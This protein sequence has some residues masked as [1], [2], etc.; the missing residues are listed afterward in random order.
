V[1]LDSPIPAGLEVLANTACLVFGAQQNCSSTSTP[2]DASPVLQVVKTYDGPPLAAGALLTFHLAVTNAGDQ[3]AADLTVTE[4]VPDH[5]TFVAG[6]STSGW[7][8]SG[9]NAGASCTFSLSALRVGEIKDLVFAV[10][11][12]SPL[13]D[14]VTQIANA[15]C[16]HSSD[17]ST[18]SDSS[19]PLPVGVELFLTDALTADA[20][21]DGSASSGDTLTYTVTVQNTSA[22]A[23]SEVVVSLQLD[24]N[25]NLVPGSVVTDTG[26]VTTGNALGD[27]SVVLSLGELA[28]GASSS[29]SFRV[30]IGSIPPGL[31]HLSSQARA[32]GLNFADEVS[33]DPETPDEDDPTLTPLGVS[34]TPIQ[35]IPTLDSIGFG[36]LFVG[37]ALAGLRFLRMP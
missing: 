14:G 29:A 19:T 15:A 13:P 1:K 26:T 32:V 10:R 2:L 22:G 12:D 4:T 5:S 11:A 25:V 33:D 27:S 17:G 24:P 30:V 3:D 21:A 16:L 23:A 31:D 9:V 35:E 8:C 34:L 6:S 18:C 36:L 28:A 20:N 37:L 7:T